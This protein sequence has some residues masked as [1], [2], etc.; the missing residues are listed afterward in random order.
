MRIPSATSASKETRFAMSSRPSQLPF[1]MA[2]KPSKMK[3][4]M[5]NEGSSIAFLHMSILRHLSVPAWSS[6]ATVTIRWMRRDSN[7]T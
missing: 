2:A 1:E 3:G 6:I 4:F 5:D 7:L